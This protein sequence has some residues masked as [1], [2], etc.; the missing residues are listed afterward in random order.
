MMT[1]DA[2]RNKSRV[3]RIMA[4]STIGF[5]EKK[6]SPAPH[7]EQRSSRTKTFYHAP[8]TRVIGEG[9]FG[10]VHRG[11]M[12][13]IPVAIKKIHAAGSV[14]LPNT[15]LSAEF[16][17]EL[18]ILTALDCPRDKRTGHRP[19]VTFFAACFDPACLVMVWWCWS[20]CSFHFFADSNILVLIS[21]YDAALFI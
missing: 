3:I 4:T 9:A 20:S 5:P 19:I 2:R 13:N 17:R 8:T 10:T 15:R 16:W 1:T 14:M 7:Q 6:Y 18:G 21:Y 11:T 12:F